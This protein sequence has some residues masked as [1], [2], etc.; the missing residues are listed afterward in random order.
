MPPKTHFL[1]Q[2]MSV[3]T[4]KLLTEGGG[5]EVTV[6]TTRLAKGNVDI[7]TCHSVAHLLEGKF[8][9]AGIDIA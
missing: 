8:V 4:H 5:V 7:Y 2:S 3:Q 9:E 6:D 1:L